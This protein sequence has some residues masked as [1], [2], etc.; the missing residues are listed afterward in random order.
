MSEKIAA[1]MEAHNANFRLFFGNVQRR[2]HQINVDNGWWEEEREVGTLILLMI[3]ELIE[4][5]QAYRHHNPQDEK[6]PD[7]SEAEVEFA[8]TIIRIMDFAEYYD[9]DVA[10]ALLAKLERNRERGHK[11]GGK[12]Y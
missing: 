10:G 2:A 9:L 8:D 6:L 5:S 3:E 12:A 7:F 11:H 4:A 1:L